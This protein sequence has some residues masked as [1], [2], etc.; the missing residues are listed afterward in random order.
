[1]IVHT[2]AEFAEAMKWLYKNPVER[3]KL[4]KQAAQSV[5][6]RFS[7]EK[8]ESLLSQHYQTILTEEKRK[9]NFQQIFGDDPALWFL[10]CQKER[11]IF[12]EDGTIHL[13]SGRP[14][15][16][17]LFEKSKG[18]VFHFSRYFPRNLKLKAWAINLDLHQ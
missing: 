17:G 11:S 7:A 18:T 1:M 8:M 4:G 2:L 16:D 6:Q 5:R 3:T 9:I 15:S 13:K 12:A 14:A 10:S